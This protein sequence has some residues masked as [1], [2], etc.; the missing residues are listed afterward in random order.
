MQLSRGKS[1]C[2]FGVVVHLEST[3]EFGKESSRRISSICAL[4]IGSR[5]SRGV[6]TVVD[7]VTPVPGMSPSLGGGIVL[8][9]VEVRQM[10][11]KHGDRV[12]TNR[13]EP[14][15]SEVVVI[16]GRKSSSNACCAETCAVCTSGP[17]MAIASL[18]DQLVE[19]V[20]VPMDPDDALLRRYNAEKFVHHAIVAECAL[21]QENGH[22]REQRVTH[23]RVLAGTLV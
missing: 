17:D 6:V 10:K 3:K 19:E 12:L 23:E 2:K 11:S 9:Y 7:V 22:S 20:S 14:L 5:I 4:A 8:I 1:L 16:D 21:G 13:T 18:V 15:G